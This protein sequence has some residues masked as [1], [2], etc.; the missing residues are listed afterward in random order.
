[1]T[2]FPKKLI[3]I[4][5]LVEIC[6]M[7][8]TASFTISDKSIILLSMEKSVFW[9]FVKSIRSLTSLCKWI[10]SDKICLLYSF[11]CSGSLII[12]S[13]IASIEPRITVIGVRSSWEIFAIKF[14]RIFSNRSLSLELL[15]SWTANLSILS[16]SSPISSLW[17]T[18]VV[19]S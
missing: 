7:L 14:C 18:S 12:P 1:M 2:L 19:T 11:N 8:L 3:F 17:S 5:F 6:F 10:L 15:S 9:S 4:F 16:A 13:Q